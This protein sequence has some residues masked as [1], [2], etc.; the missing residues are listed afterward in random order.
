MPPLFP[1]R[2]NILGWFIILR[3]W[4]I[5]RLITVANLLP[6]AVVQLLRIKIEI[7]HTFTAP[8]RI[9]IL[10]NMFSWAKLLYWWMIYEDKED[11]KWNY[12]FFKA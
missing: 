2:N 9:S 5:L 4:N 11:F 10:Q 12:Y 1:N 8:Q 7:I 3:E 6:F